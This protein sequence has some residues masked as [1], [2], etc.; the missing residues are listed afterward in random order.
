[1]REAIPPPLTLTFS[2][3]RA[4]LSTGCVFMT[5]YFVKHRDNFTLFSTLAAVVKTELRVAFYQ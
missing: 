2:C 1:M 3:C 4:H 5:W